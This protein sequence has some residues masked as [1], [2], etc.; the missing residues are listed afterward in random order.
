LFAEPVGEHWK[1][2]CIY[3]PGEM[4]RHEYEY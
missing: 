2:G 4:F 1:G 3:E